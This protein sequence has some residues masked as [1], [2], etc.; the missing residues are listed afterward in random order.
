MYVEHHTVE[1]DCNDN[2]HFN[3]FLAIRD[4]LEVE[5]GGFFHP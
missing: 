1:H 2:D 5:V 3:S 4:S